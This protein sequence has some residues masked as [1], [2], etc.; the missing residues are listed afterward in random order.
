M[1]WSFF[2]V[3]SPLWKLVTD[4]KTCYRLEDWV[5]RGSYLLFWCIF[6]DPTLGWSGENHWV[7]ARTWFS[8]CFFPWIHVSRYDLFSHILHLKLCFLLTNEWNVNGIL[9]LSAFYRYDST[10]HS[11]YAFLFL[12]VARKFSITIKKLPISRF[13]SRI[14]QCLRI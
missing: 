14:Y 6:G 11:S 10:I 2:Y 9:Q 13:R 12:S 3:I 4:S 1:R 8:R 7:A 5:S